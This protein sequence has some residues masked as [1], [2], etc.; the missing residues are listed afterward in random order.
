MNMEIQEL[1]YKTTTVPT[2]KGMK[3]DRT[4][5]KVLQPISISVFYYENGSRI[6]RNRS[7]NGI[8]IGYGNG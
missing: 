1:L 5:G 2:T 8:Y 4:G 7:E 6:T 3:T